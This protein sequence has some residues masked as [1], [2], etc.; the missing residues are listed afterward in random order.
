MAAQ[1]KIHRAAVSRK[2]GELKLISKLA[3]CLAL[4]FG[5]ATFLPAAIIG[6][7]PPAFPLTA[8]RVAGLPK[9]KQPAWEKD[10]ARST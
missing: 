1:T 8:E 5:A 2:N 7:N 6:T 3:L 9:D 4:M 10:L